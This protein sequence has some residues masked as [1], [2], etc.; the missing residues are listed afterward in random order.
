[1]HSD[2]KQ[3]SH[4]VEF[5]AMPD[6]T[7][8]YVQFT[9]I[10]IYRFEYAWQKNWPETITNQKG[11]NSQLSV[12][13][14]RLAFQ[15]VPSPALVSYPARNWSDRTLA[16]PQG[17]RK[18]HV[19]VN[20]SKWRMES[21]DP[22]VGQPWLFF[23]RRKPLADKTSGSNRPQAEPAGGCHARDWGLSECRL[24]VCGMPVTEY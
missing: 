12:L 17:E 19:T 14:S 20:K 13:S 8:H 5:P 6:C 21:S 3:M 2:V 7:Q 1:M 24:Q 11:L 9:T 18:N 23:S 15:R 10:R 16:G 22:C 4:S